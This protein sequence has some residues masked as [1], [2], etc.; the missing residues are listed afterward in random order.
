MNALDEVSLQI[1]W[2]RLIS[3]VEEQAQTLVRTAFSTSVR[4]AGDLSAGVFDEAGLMMAQAVTGT[5]GHVNAMAEAALHIIRDIGRNNIR[6]GDVYITNDP[7]K[8]TGHLHDITV[9]QPSYRAGRLVGFFAA[10]AHV[11]DI[12]GRGF[13]PDAR[14]LYEEG[15]FIPIMKLIDRGVINET[16]LAFVRAN[17]RESMQVVGDIFSLVACTDTGHKRL[18]EMMDEFDIGGLGRLASFIF[19]RSRDA[20]VQAIGTLPRGT[21][22]NQMAIDGYDDEVDLRVSLTIA[23]DHIM[24]DFA[25]TSKASSFGVNVPLI[26]TRAYCCYGLKCAIAPA[27]PNNSASLAPFMV[28]ATEGSIVHAT[29]PSPVAARHVIGHMIP[30]LVLGALHHFLPGR[31]PAESA[32]ALWNIQISARQTDGAAHGRHE[33]LMFNS[34][35]TGARASLD[36]MSATAFPSGVYAMS[37][38]ATEQVGPIVVWRKELLPDSGGAGEYRGGLGQRIEIEAAEGYQLQFNAMFDRVHHPARGRSGGMPG[39][40]GAVRLSDGTVLNG[41]G[42]QPVPPGKRLVLDLPGGGGF[43]KPTDRPA[44]RVRQDIEAGYVTP[45]H[46]AE[47]YGPPHGESS[48]RKPDAA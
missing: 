30:D 39:R 1:M 46:S 43:G 17:V 29:S 48:E 34:G 4:E 15:L 12:G 20:T 18:M 23:E 33:I 2:N 47:H 37:V 25:G 45:G 19:S 13:G 7:W 27:V 31:I 16:L 28:T 35:G 36:G 14:E 9:M 6:E 40:A 11:I 5:P 8:G 38:E 44:G 22:Q 3:V 32:G 10:T 21:F 24:A 41:K 42:R 26:Y